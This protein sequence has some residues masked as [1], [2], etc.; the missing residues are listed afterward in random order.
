MSPR[1]KIGVLGIGAIGTVMAYQLQRLPSHDIFYFS[2]TKKKTLKLVVES[3]PFDIPVG[4]KTTSE[5]LKLDWLFICIKEHQYQEAKH[6]FSKL[7]SPSTKVVV[8]RNGLHLKESL[9]DFAN[10]DHILECLIDC[11][12]ERDKK[13]Y[14]NCIKM[15]KLTVPKSDLAS[16]FETLFNRSGIEITQSNDFKTDAWK[17]LLESATLGAVLCIYNR[18]CE[19]FQLSIA[20]HLY[21]NL[22]EESIKVAKADGAKIEENFTDKMINKLMNYPKTKG[23]SMLTDLRQGKPLELG[24][25]NGIISKLGKQYG[26]ETSINDWMIRILA[27][28]KIESNL[29]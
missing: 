15:P 2:R 8:I 28:T 3:Q 23:S 25:K 17:K 6:W 1:T 19:I 16:E 7:I 12:T 29:S 4:I 27:K 5:T 20:K 24:A 22:M 26:I 11:P 21:R 13:G 9:L 14:Y 18:T 10:E